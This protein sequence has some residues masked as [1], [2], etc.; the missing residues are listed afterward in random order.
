MSDYERFEAVQGDPWSTDPVGDYSRHPR[1]LESEASRDDSQVL[2]RMP[3][4]GDDGS[5]DQY[6]QYGPSS[7]HS[8]R[9][10]SSAARPGVPAPV[11]VVV[12]MGLVL[13][14]G[15]PFVMWKSS[16]S[17]AALDEPAWEMPAPDA[18]VAPAWS[19]GEVDSSWQDTAPAAMATAEPTAP[20]NW[21]G[22]TDLI[23]APANAPYAY[24][25]DAA[26]PA[27]VDYSGAY[28]EASAAPYPSANPLVQA[29]AGSW[30]PAASPSYPE[31]HAPGSQPAFPATA[32]LPANSWQDRA[33]SPGGTPSYGT[34]Q[35]VPGVAPQEALVPGSSIAT[36]QPES[37]TPGYGNHPAFQ[38]NPYYMGNTSQAAAAP[39]SNYQV[40]QGGN[41]ASQYPNS[42]PNYAAGVGSSANLYPAPSYP[43]TAMSPQAPVPTSSMPAAGGTSYPAQPL[44]PNNMYQRSTTTPYT[45]ATT[46]AAPVGQPYYGTGVSNGASQQSVARLNGTIQ[47][48][49]ARQAY[50]DSAQPSYY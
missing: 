43:Q 37:M 23:G 10:R 35:P 16:P 12:G 40:P 29:P 20:A 42:A 46:P 25:A 24:N 15:A 50:N 19:A 9:R 21:G 30:D 48:P 49:V 13:V 14:I 18:P 36:P 31:T 41:V 7:S 3:N 34:N 2:A 22:A 45:P 5:G 8:R 1:E 6:R 33:L 26:S 32:G 38:T 27:P 39:P 47:E 28:G 17:E 44:A 4:V 11:W